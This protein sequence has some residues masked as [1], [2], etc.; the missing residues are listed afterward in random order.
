MKYYK[1][2]EPSMTNWAK[3]NNNNNNNNKNTATKTIYFKA[4]MYKYSWINNHRQLKL[5]S[6]NISK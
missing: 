6:N 2:I 5:Y 4:F 1:V 3:N